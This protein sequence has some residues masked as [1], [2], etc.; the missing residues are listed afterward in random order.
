MGG[1]EDVDKGVHGEEGGVGG[2]LNGK[3]DVEGEGDGVQ[4]ELEGPGSGPVASC[5][6]RAQPGRLPL[7]SSLYTIYGNARATR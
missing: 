4:Q 2:G 6:G 5:A 7:Q 3:L 1:Q